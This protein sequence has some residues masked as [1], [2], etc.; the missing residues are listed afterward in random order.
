[1]HIPL[2]QV[3]KRKAREGFRKEHVRHDHD[4]WLRP[5]EEPPLG[6]HLIT[7]RFTYQHHGIYVG[8]GLVVH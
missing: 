3:F 4:R 8:G 6:A 7:P 1:M 2:I 5:Q